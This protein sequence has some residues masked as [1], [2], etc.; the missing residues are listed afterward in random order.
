[1]SQIAG[2]DVATR[3]EGGL[4]CLRHASQIGGKDV[5]ARGWRGAQVPAACFAE[6]VNY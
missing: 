6:K 2:K 3:G 4:R 5:A 1:L